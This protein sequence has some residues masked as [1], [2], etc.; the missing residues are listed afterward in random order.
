M[1]ATCACS[2]RT[3]RKPPADPVSIGARSCA[4]QMW[5]LGI[6]QERL[7][8]AAGGGT[9]TPNSCHSE[10]SEESLRWPWAGWLDPNVAVF[11]WGG[12]GGLHSAAANHSAADSRDLRFQHFQ[13]RYPNQ[14]AW[15]FSGLSDADTLSTPH[16]AV[17]CFAFPCTLDPWTPPAWPSCWRRFCRK[18]AIRFWPHFPPTW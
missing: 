3:C 8:Q 17:N 16:L 4:P 9:K 10:R 2:F 6:A 11:F 12:S 1:P 5:D 14:P 13:R 7:P 18:R 15:R